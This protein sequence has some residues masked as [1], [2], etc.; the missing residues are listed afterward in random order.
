[1]RN[2]LL[3]VLS[4]TI[5]PPA[6]ASEYSASQSQAT[7]ATSDSIP[8]SAAT[9]VEKGDW[10]GLVPILES[11]LKSQPGNAQ[12]HYQ[13]GQ[14]YVQLKKYTLA[15]D[16]LRKAIRL[17]H[18]DTFSVKA[19]ALLATMPAHLIAPKQKMA[20]ARVK[21]HRVAAAGLTRPRILSFYATWA[22]PCKQLRA[23]LDKAKNEFGEQVEIYTIDVD[24]PKN[25]KIIDQYDV[26]PIPTVVFLDQGGKVID[27]FVGYSGANDLESSIKKLLNKG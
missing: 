26:S 13:L 20:E 16:E 21:G 11:Y 27:Y 9:A 1:M 3:L 12:A 7:A 22:E 2:T 23:D 8:D 18:G 14:A 24:D 17:G 10:K 6:L 15:K 5:L 4:L 19:N 25:E